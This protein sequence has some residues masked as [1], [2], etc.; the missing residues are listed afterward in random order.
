M[1]S[2]AHITFCLQHLAF[3]VPLAQCIIA[4]YLSA[5]RCPNSMECCIFMLQFYLF[6]SFSYFKKTKKKPSSH[7]SNGGAWRY[8]FILFNPETRKPL[9]TD[10][11]WWHYLFFFS[12][13]CN[14]VTLLMKTPHFW[15]HA[16]I[17]TL[18]TLVT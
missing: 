6:D 9:S 11:T 14:V 1:V 2:W 16:F 5:T 18:V 15:S 4:Y 10:W 12:I 8:L 17:L 3:H 13:L 7:V